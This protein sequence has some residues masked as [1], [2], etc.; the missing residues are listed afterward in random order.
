[1]L[2]RVNQN[3]LKHTREPIY[4]KIGLF[5]LNRRGVAVGVFYMSALQ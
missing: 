2:M 1:M 4:S 5:D 3:T